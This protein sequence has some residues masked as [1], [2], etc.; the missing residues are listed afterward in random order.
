MAVN[1]QVLGLLEEMMDEGKTPEEVCRDYPEL[2]VEVQRRWQQIHFIDEQIEVM[3]PSLDSAPRDITNT[4]ALLASGLPLIPGY[5]VESVLGSGGMGVVY[6]ARQLALDRHVAVK[7]LLA[8][9]FA[10]Q[11]EL[12]RFHREIAALADLRHPNIVQVYDA[13]DV[14]GR[15]YFS[16]EV[17]EG[18]SLAQSLSGTPQPTQRAATLS[19]TLAQAID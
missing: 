9:P 11:Q 1:A 6:I 4:P 12:G 14:D 18:G 2:L 10:S 15:P 7:M 19:L 17:V 16:M 5:E 8:G 13:G 3:L